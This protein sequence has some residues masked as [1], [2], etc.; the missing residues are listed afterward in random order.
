MSNKSFTKYNNVSTTSHLVKYQSDMQ[1]LEILQ[2]KNSV[3]P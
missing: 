2:I 1:F 3:C